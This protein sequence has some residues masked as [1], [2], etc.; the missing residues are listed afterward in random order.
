MCG[1]GRCPSRPSVWARRARDRTAAPARRAVGR[2]GMSEMTLALLGSGEFDPWSEPVE[3]WLLERTRNPAGLALV[4]PTAAAHE[5]DASFSAWGAK[6]LE[7]YAG[8]GGPAE[9]VEREAG[10]GG[11]REG[12]GAK[13]GE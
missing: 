4:V 8:L 6:G 7:H 5:G 13:V 11:A 3:R 9:V 1:G 2:R 12:V 10:A